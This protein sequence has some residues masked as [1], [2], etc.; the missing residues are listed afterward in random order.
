MGN[1]KEFPY[2]EKFIENNYLYCAEFSKNI[3]LLHG[4]PAGHIQRI[5]KSSH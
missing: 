5:K 4:G 3:K 2:L 1:F